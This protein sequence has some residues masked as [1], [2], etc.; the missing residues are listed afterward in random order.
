MY[1]PAD[2]PL[3]NRSRDA[4]AGKPQYLRTLRTGDFQLSYYLNY[5]DQ[6]E[7][8]LYDLRDDPGEFYNRWQDPAY[9]SVRQELLHTMLD[10]VIQVVDPKPERT[11]PY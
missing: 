11:A 5:N 9:R 6:P 10:A 1:E 8:E 4:I 7:G 3:P 2:V